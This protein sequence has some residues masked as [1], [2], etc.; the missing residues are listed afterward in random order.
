MPAASLNFSPLMCVPLPVPAEPKLSCPGFC[1][2]SAISS[3]TVLMPGR[4]RDDQH[5]RLSGQR[6]DL[7]EV[8]GRIEGQVGI[9]R[10]VVGLRRG[11]HEQRVAVGR[12]LG[13]EGRADRSAG[14]GA[15]LDDHRLSPEFGK[16]LPER[17]RQDVGGAARRERH[18]D[19]H[20]LGRVGCA[21]ARCAPRSANAS[22]TK[23]HANFITGFL[24]N[25]RCPRLRGNHSIGKCSFTSLTQAAD[26]SSY[27]PSLTG[28]F[29]GSSVRPDASPCSTSS[30]AKSS[31]V[32]PRPIRVCTASRVIDASGIGT[33]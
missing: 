29:S 12:R 21:C 4:G 22:T 1:L 7:D 32:M 23:R 30:L 10:R 24:R 9:D 18:D 6:R 3:A 19:V 26:A 11:M 17:A 31:S 2:A 33:P 20:R 28:T 14:A 13:D 16:L 5:V 25:N 27:R 8:L 15:V